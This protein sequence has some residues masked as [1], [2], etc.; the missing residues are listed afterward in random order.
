[1]RV[2]LVHPE[3]SPQR[4]PWA[5]QRWDLVVDLGRSSRFSAQRWQERLRCP[6]L[7]ADSFR[8]G[9]ED[10]RRVRNLFASGRG[11]LLDE[12]GIDWWDLTSLV[13]V[14]EA[15]SLIT[16]ERMVAD[17]RPATELWTTRVGWSSKLMAAL[18]GV[19]LR[20]FGSNGLAR[21]TNR[22]LH[23]A[24]ILR[25]FRAGQIKEILL[26]KYD[27]NY[28][29]RS[30]LI[31]RQSVSK[32]PVVLLPSAYRNVS[33]MAADY[34]RLLT[35]QAFLLVATRQNAHEFSRPANVEIRDLAAY[36]G[37]KAP[38][39]ETAS[40]LERWRLLQRKLGATRE[41]ELLASAGVF[42]NFS[43][44][45]RD[46]LV[47]RNAWRHVLEREPVQAVLCGDDSNIYTRL[48]VLLAAKRKIPTVDFHHGAL[49]G[50][51]LLKD[52]PCDIYLAK[53]EMEQD[54]LVR[55][56]G[57]PSERIVI[58]PPSDV[59]SSVTR[60]A[61]RSD[62]TAVVFFSE[63]YEVAGMRPEEV[64]REL[65]PSL[66][67]VARENGRS[68]V[69]KLH[70]FESRS[71]RTK[72]VRD[73]LQSDDRDLVTV[74]DG[75]LTPELMNRA[76]FGITVESTTAMDC[77]RNGV[78]CFL[79]GWLSMSSYEY[80]KQYARFGVGDAL[81]D[82]RQVSEIPRR[83]AETK[84]QPVSRWNLFPTPNPALLR[85]WLTSSENQI[86]R[87]IS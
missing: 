61:D 10:L 50:R 35:E 11:H 27:S 36:A 8:H 46:G 74:I 67:R 2:L 17:V 76:W 16:F 15:E 51:Y 6:V 23:Y 32:K 75:P 30:Q 45:F 49:D 66:C 65:L 56:C 9:M 7:R 86:T 24:R 29:F 82:V 38:T 53:N 69:I 72:L 31:T 77:M 18:L 58:G 37:H 14:P 3:D 42:Q 83:L 81:Q 40:L 21:S 1:M 48:T 73:V 43:R 12:E 41:Y 70:P 62:K 44:W 59:E 28:Q 4:G 19:E 84:A 80:P 5:V 20:A 47:A 68:V 87:S 34:A 39:K 13:V 63:P 33:R 60:T 54:Y 55:F 79:C 22:V 25:R 64:Y 57:L 71:Q 52:L 26:D 78:R 85:R